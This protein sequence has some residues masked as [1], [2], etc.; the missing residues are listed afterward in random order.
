MMDTVARGVVAAGHPET[1]AA[2]AE[3]LKE[4]GNA[5]DAAIAAMFA[6][7]ACEPLLSGL[8][9]GGYMLVRNPA[10]QSVLLDFFVA[11]PGEGRASG[12]FAPLVPNEVNFGDATQVFHIGASSCG[13]YG[14]PAG[15]A[16]AHRRFAIAP[17]ERLAERGAQLAR[18][19]TELNREQAY[20]LGILEGII[21]FTPG[22]AEIYAPEGRPLREGEKIFN[23][24]L[25]DS[26]ERLANDGAEPFYTGDIASS[27]LAALDEFG[28]LLTSEDLRSFTV[29]DRDPIVSEYR[30]YQVLLNPPPSAGGILIAYALGLLEQDDSPPTP[31]RLVEVMNL[32]Q[33]ERTQEFLT[34]LQSPGLLDTFLASKLGS[35]THISALD[36]DGWACSVTSSNGEGCG[37]VAPGTGIH[38]NNMLGEEDLNPLG[39][40]KHAPG[41]RLPSMMAPT[42]LVR[43]GEPMLVLG[44]AG[45]NRIRSAVLQ[46]VVNWVDRGMDLKAAVQAPRIHVEDGTVYLEPGAAVDGIDDPD[47][48]LLRFRALNLY[49]GGVEAVGLNRRTRELV[50]AGDPRRG[51]AAASG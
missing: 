47:H 51:G 28:G 37:I 49:F 50:G 5:V 35:T 26:I 31:H 45:S 32:A 27:V 36:C 7:F 46:V 16:E 6:S 29:A 38:L 18:E 25:G 33:T 15:I 48:T 22:A 42:V 21:T 3:I 40:H 4:G 41:A 17:L 2:G 14:V 34:Q 1:A 24:L 10:G 30:D 20:V 12:D 9:A 8:G 19:G 11:A 39:F 44:S 43:D 13:T 23:P